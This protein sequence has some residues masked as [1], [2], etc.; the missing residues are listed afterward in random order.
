MLRS[1]PQPHRP[2]RAEAPQLDTRFKKERR[3][4]GENGARPKKHRPFERGVRAGG[5]GGG[6]VFGHSDGG[7]VLRRGGGALRMPPH[8]RRGRRHLLRALL[9]PAVRPASE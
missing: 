8:R 5:G 3:K 7:A 9:P 4:G 1:A 2:S 6:G